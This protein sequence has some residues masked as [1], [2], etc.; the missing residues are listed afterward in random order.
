MYKLSQP[1]HFEAAST[2]LCSNMPRLPCNTQT[3]PTHPVPVRNA[4]PLCAV[5]MHY[6]CGNTSCSLPLRSHKQNQAAA[7]EPRTYI[8][9][10]ATQKRLMSTRKI[11]THKTSRQILHCRPR[12]NKSAAIAMQL[13]FSGQMQPISQSKASTQCSIHFKLSARAC[14]KQL[15]CQNQN[16]PPLKKPGQLDGDSSTVRFRTILGALH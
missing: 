5:N 9:Y 15:G 2:D 7:A 12:S 13:E 6:T 16:K 14:R 3:H 8:N 11:H 1:C 10:E 4:Y